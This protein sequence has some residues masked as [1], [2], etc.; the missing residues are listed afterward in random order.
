MLR[1]YQFVGG[2]T[3]YNHDAQ[4]VDE[5]I[6]HLSQHIICEPARLRCDALIL[7][8]LDESLVLFASAGTNLSVV[9][10]VYTSMKSAGGSHYSHAKTYP[11]PGHEEQT[12]RSLLTVDYAIYNHYYSRFNATWAA[13]IAARPSL[14]DDLATLKC[15]CRIVGAYTEPYKHQQRAFFTDSMEYTKRLKN[16]QHF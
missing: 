9:E 7:E 1:R 4:K 13:A 2:V 5:F 15:C 14:L 16:G 6:E 12:A 11:Q 3:S 8:R 10:M